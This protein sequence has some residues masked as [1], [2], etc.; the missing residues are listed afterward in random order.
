MGWVSP[1]INWL[2]EQPAI[3]PDTQ[4]SSSAAAALIEV[5]PQVLFVIGHSI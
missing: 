2:A 5:V 3:K 1:D 4:Q